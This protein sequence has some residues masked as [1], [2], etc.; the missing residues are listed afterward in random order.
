MKRYRNWV[1]VLAVALAFPL[2]LAAQNVARGSIGGTIYDTSGGIV[3]EAKLTL[4]SDYGVREG[5]AGSDGT[6]VFSSLETGKYTLRVE[7]TNLRSAKSR[8]S[9]C[10]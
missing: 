2:A 3:P 1:I 10:A 4:T 8:A 5:K 7:Y 9:V 6:Y